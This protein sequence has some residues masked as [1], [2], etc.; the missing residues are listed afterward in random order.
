MF[1]IRSCGDWQLCRRLGLHIYPSTARPKAFQTVADWSGIEMSCQ[2]DS[3]IPLRPLSS[4]VWTPDRTS[5]CN[6]LQNRTLRSFSSDTICFSIPPTQVL[7]DSLTDARRSRIV[8]FTTLHMHA[9]VKRTSALPA[10]SHLPL[11]SRS[12]QCPF[13]R[14]QPRPCGINTL[15]E[16]SPASADLSTM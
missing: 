2:V 4:V 14:A 12:P 16:V 15:H 10:A 11:L 9:L 8:S 3:V 7:H 6:H 5:I 1:S 13:D